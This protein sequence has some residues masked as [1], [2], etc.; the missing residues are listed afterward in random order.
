[1]HNLRLLAA[2]TALALGAAGM[3]ASAQ[4]A[5]VAAS[6]SATAATPATP[7]EPAPPA[8]PAAAAAVDVAVGADVKSSDG[9]SVGT[10]KALDAN[11][12]VILDDKGTTFALN[13]DLFTAGAAGGVALKVTAKQLADARAGAGAKAA[14]AQN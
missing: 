4:D 9:T 5:G 10:V 2:T 7:A 8:V 11:G 12:N 1:M 13:K 3:P 6:P 14:T